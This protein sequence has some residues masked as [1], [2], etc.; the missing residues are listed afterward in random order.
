MTPARTRT[1]EPR[2]V[3]QCMSIL[4]LLKVLYLVID[5]YFLFILMI[6][7]EVGS[8]ENKESDLVIKEW[9]LF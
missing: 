2:I 8:G 1:Q 9:I 3:V 4:C 7:C 5:V 6:N